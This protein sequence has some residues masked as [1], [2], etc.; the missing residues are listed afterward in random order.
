MQRV[1]QSIA[2]RFCQLVRRLA[3]IRVLAKLAE[4]IAEIKYDIAKV[5]CAV[6]L[7]PIGCISVAMVRRF[8]C[9]AKQ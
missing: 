4:T 8:S 9:L 6:N 1:A 2:Q 7:E 3:A 5:D